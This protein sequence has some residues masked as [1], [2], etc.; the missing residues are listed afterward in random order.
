MPKKKLFTTQAQKQRELLILSVSVLFGLCFLLSRVGNDDLSNYT[1][2]QMPVSEIFPWL[3]RGFSNWGSRIFIN[4][5]VLL[6]SRSGYPGLVLYASGSM[7]IFLK[8]LHLLYG[9]DPDNKASLFI[10][11]VAMIYPFRV[12]HTSGWA[13]GLT[14]Y[15][16]PASCMLMALVPIKKHCDGEKIRIPLMVL[17]FLAALYASNSEQNMIILLGSYIVAVLFFLFQKKWSTRI[18]ILGTGA[19]IN[20][21]LILVSPGNQA[22]SSSEVQT[23]FPDFSMLDSIDRLELGTSTTLQWLLCE[24]QLLV[25]L[26]TLLMMVMIWE[27]YS[28][29][30]IRTVAVIPFAFSVLTG[31]LRFV[32][33]QLIPESAILYGPVD[34][35]G[36]FT[37]SNQGRGAGPLQFCVLLFVIAC[38]IIDLLMLNDT[39]RGCIADISLCVFG[40]GSRIM[41]GLSPTIHAS[42]NRTF[43]AF[44]FCLGAMTVHIYSTYRNKP[45]KTKFVKVLPYIDLMLIFF[46]FLSLLTTLVS[47]FY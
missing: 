24:G 11:S 32:L 47:V 17:Y 9:K 45:P 30:L 42:N 39:P 34:K 27:K 4:F 19:V 16:G 41:M 26:C 43:T 20:L 14:T 22:R 1:K 23:W 2:Y 10:I 38:I 40:M 3:A 28:H 35:Y 6:V 44:L 37:I 13:M 29:Y 25:I 5:G 31:P 46:G 18:A 12:L 15:F 21:I 7:Y 8:A 33:A 36:L